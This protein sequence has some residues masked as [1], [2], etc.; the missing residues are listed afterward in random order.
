M[1]L[2]KVINLKRAVLSRMLF[3][4]HLLL[5][6]LMTTLLNT[7]RVFGPSLNQKERLSAEMT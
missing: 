1:G 2:L 7:M 3:S 5:I 4:R 6:L